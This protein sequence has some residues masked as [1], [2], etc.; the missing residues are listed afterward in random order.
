MAENVGSKL[1]YK[2]I[3]FSVGRNVDYMYLILNQRHRS[4][5]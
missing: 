3:T 2:I 4:V 1:S 5:Y